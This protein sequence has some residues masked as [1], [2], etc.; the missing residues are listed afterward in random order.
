MKGVICDRPP[1]NESEL[2]SPRAVWS[3]AR[4]ENG[5]WGCHVSILRFWQNV[6][7]QSF[8]FRKYSLKKTV[9]SPEV[10]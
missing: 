9:Y 10:V 4:A 7:K 3:P 6:E 1:R 2:E 8:F 5:C